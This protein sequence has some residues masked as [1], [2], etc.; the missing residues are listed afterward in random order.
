MGVLF[1][2]ALICSVY[3]F[4]CVLGAGFVAISEEELRGTVFM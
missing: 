1:S 2:F 3:F 4:V